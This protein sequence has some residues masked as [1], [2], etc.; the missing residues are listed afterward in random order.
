MNSITDTLTELLTAAA[1]LPTGALQAV[2]AVACVIGAVVA[3]R[4]TILALRRPALDPQ[5][6]FDGSQKTIGR[7]RAGN[8]CEHKQ[9]FWFRCSG[10]AEQADHI[11]PWSKG[12]ATS[13]SNLQ[14]LCQPHNGRKSAWVPTRTYIWR[15]ERRRRRYFPEGED[16]KV[17]WKQGAAA[18]T[19]ASPARPASRRRR[20][21]D[22]AGVS[23]D[24]YV[25]L[26]PTD[27]Q[28]AV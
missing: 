9:P 8:Q 19:G 17:C 12:G 24:F 22:P 2:A 27:E 4:Q 16:P 1:G 28:E 18:G 11:Y 14:Y 20:K 7:R 10:G 6:L 23:P 13:V 15:L 25:G 5:R 21:N 3:G 26:R